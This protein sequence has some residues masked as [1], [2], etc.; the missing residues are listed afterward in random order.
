MNR[1]IAMNK[2]RKYNAMY[3]FGLIETIS[4]FPSY[5]KLVCMLQTIDNFHGKFFLNFVCDLMFPVLF[6]FL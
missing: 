6:K 4:S 2:H 3:F 5:V 1:S